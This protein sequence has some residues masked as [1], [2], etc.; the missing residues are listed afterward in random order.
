MI[1]QCFFF[2]FKLNQADKCIYSEFDDKEN[3]V[4]IW[5]NVDDMLIF[6]KSLVQVDMTKAFCHQYS[7]RRIWEKQM[8]Y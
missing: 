6:E 1:S 5:F 3:G 8:S 7:K 2:G 4:I